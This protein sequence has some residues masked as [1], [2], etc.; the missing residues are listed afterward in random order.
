MVL[1]PLISAGL[2]ANQPSAL[3]LTFSLPVLHYDNVKATTSMI[4]EY[5]SVE[6][7]S[8]FSVITDQAIG[9]GQSS[10]S[11]LFCSVL[12]GFDDCEM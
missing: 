10:K 8:Y 1:P 7:S 2:T 4:T 12:L 9:L 5:K 3:T 6:I 11:I